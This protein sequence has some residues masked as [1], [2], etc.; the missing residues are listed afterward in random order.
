[1]KSEREEKERERGRRQRGRRKR[2]QE[3]EDGSGAMATQGATKLVSAL[4]ESKS[5][6]DRAVCDYTS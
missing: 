1:M 2:E 3:N 4:S 5:H 6:V